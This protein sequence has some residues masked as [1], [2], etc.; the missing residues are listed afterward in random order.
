MQIPEY[1]DGKAAHN[2]FFWFGPAGTITPFH[3]DLTN[4]FMAKVIGR[5]R[6]LL[7]P[8]W[9][10]PLMRNLFDVYCEIDGRTTSPAP[11]ASFG[12]PQILECFLEPGEILFLPIG[13]LHFVEAIEISV[14]MSFTNF[15]FDDNDFTSFYERHRSV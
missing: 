9:D 8:S 11:P 4:N 2:G 13:C 10:M 6:I 12:Q 14:T 5:K 7:V 3:H 15:H 1:L